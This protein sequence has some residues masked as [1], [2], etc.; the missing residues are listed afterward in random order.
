MPT[1]RLAIGSATVLVAA[2]PLSGLLNPNLASPELL[3]AL[4]VRAG[5]PP[6]RADLLAT[7]IVEW[8]SP[9]Q[10]RRAGSTKALQYRGAGL[11]Y[12]PPGAPFET[13]AEL[14]DVLGMTPTLFAALRPNLSL[15]T[16]RPPLPALAPP[17][18]RDALRSLGGTS[19][20]SA[21]SG[22]VFRIVATA[23]GR[24]I[25]RVSREAIVQLAPSARPWRVLSWETLSPST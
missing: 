22:T 8:R 24:G 11:D 23:N 21:E 5:A 2:E 10:T 19:A 1:A 13:V 9:G 18:L 6:A 20:S 16:D 17:M 4:L 25:A 12:G 14:L 15:F 3:R 7:A